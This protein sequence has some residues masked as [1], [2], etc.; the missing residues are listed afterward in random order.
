MKFLKYTLFAIFAVGAL[1][2]NFSEAANDKPKSLAEKIDSQVKKYV[3]DENFQGAILVA[4]KGQIVFKNAY[5]FADR[6]K[7][8]KN[9]IETK[10]LVGS[11][12]KSFTAVTVMQLVEAGL[13]DLNAPLKK[14]IPNLKD[15][16][17]KNL[18][19]HFLLK[20]QSGIAP[21]FDDLTNFENENI[22]SQELLNIINRT[23]LSFPP[24]AK[25]EYSN[26]NY[27]LC[28]IAIENVTKKSFAQVLEEKTFT[29]LQMQ[30][31]GIERASKTPEARAKG[32]RKSS[33]GIEND[34]NVVAYALGAGDIYSTVDDILKW[35]QAIFGDKFLSK[36][37]KKLLFDGA[38]KN[39]GYYGHGFRIQPYQRGLENKD[40]G[41]LIRHGGTMD[42]F[43]SN[44]HH[45]LDDD[46]TVIVLGN[47]RPFPIREMTFEIKETA[48]GIEPGKRNNS[49][50]E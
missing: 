33:S 28:A 35:E 39:F 9:T 34:E 4:R 45:Y 29:P 23:S 19:L 49:T 2:V 5:G 47:I 38:D 13:M 15:D 18:T 16:L 22:T 36:K 41:I 21:S 10:F 37:I 46:L 32:Y 14:Y 44:F 50:L 3:T 6:E 30:N 43:M 40:T 17:A 25:Y 48:L 27:T 24:G 7:K 31:S 8:L 11:L 12:T 42:G 26:L 20:Q 1:L